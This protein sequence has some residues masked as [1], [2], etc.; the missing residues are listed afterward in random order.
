MSFQFYLSVDQ[1]ND[2]S[3]NPYSDKAILPP[4][5]LSQIVEVI[6]ESNLP[7]PLIFRITNTNAPSGKPVYIGVKEFTAVED[8]ILPDV[9]YRKLGSPEQ[10]EITLVQNIPKATSIKLR[11]DQ[12]YANIT[13]WKFFLENKLNLYYTTLTSGDIMII[14]DENLRYELHIDEINGGANTTA[15]IVDTDITLEMVPL[16][17]QL[18]KEQML[19]FNS[20]PHNNIV[21]IEHELDVDNLKSFSD[22]QFIPTI[23]KIDL[24]RSKSGIVLK[25]IN[26][27]YDGKKYDSLFNADLI[28]GLDKI[29]T[30]ENFHYSTMDQ[31]FDIEYKLDHGKH[32]DGIKSVEIDYKDD[33]IVNKLHRIQEELKL[34]E[35][36]IDKYLYVIPYTWDTNANITLV[37][38]EKGETYAPEEEDIPDENQKQCSNCLK[39]ISVQSYDLHQSFCLRNNVRCVKC[40]SVFL[41]K[42]P[43]THWHCDLCTNGFYANTPLL[44]SKHV[45]L[46][47]LDPYTCSQ[48]PD[49]T[50][51]NDFFDL[52]TKHKSTNC[53][54]KMHQCRFCHLIV[55]Q[56][57]ATYQDRFENLTH[58]ENS[59]GNKTNECYKCGKIVR[60]KDFKKHVKMHELDKV[61][62]NQMNKF[63]FN[64]CCNENCINLLSG[65]SSNEMGLCDICYGPLYV[66]QHDPTYLKLQIRIERKYM[67]QLSKGCGNDYCNNEYCRTGNRSL[68]SKPFKELMQ[69]LNQELFS[70]IHSPKL[71]VNKS[72]KE[73][74]VGANKVWFC[75]NESVSNKKVLLDILRSEGVYEDEIVYKAVNERSDEQAIRSW[76][77]EHA[78]TRSTL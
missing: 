24:T 19:A 64:K 57:E 62:F 56:E 69:L 16:N 38:E 66:A 51:F 71:P 61:E 18:A 6:P 1:S 65:V 40:D 43:E 23:Y 68:Q 14:Q 12:F 76:L 73:S 28:V 11:P 50:P 41:K 9:I 39:Y 31:D 77:R 54:A 49:H 20:N 67:I 52:V 59:C 55:P 10:V 35:D 7:H 21:E 26:R 45:K 70:N 15:C 44:Q 78:I 60:I 5:V 8:A 4:S 13:N 58:H 53:P 29:V 47:H 32:S 46:Y 25:L 48:C 17:D 63:T 75:V 30:L 22:S 37:V 74:D 27:D 42:I 2:R 72:R 3:L 33:I 36:D 34:D